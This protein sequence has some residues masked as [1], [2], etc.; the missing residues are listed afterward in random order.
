MSHT[1]PHHSSKHALTYNFAKL[2]DA[3]RKERG[4]KVRWL[5]KHTG[6]SEASLRNLF[7]ILNVES[8]DESD[9]YFFIYQDGPRRETFEKLLAF[10][11][12]EEIERALKALLDFEETLQASLPMK[13]LYALAAE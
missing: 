2:L 13:R 8:L 7:R 6:V 4:F 1:S 10:E 5:A 9:K 11:W 12:P 3:F